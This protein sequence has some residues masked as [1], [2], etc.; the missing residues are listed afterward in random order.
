MQLFIDAIVAGASR[1]FGLETFAAD[2]VFRH[3]A[4]G[5]VPSIDTLYREKGAVCPLCG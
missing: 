1:V 2:P 4:G 5:A 3:L